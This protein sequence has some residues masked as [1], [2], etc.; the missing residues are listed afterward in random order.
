MAWLYEKSGAW[1]A[2]VRHT[3]DSRLVFGAFGLAVCVVIPYYAVEGIMAWSNPVLDE[4]QIA[5]LRKRQGMSSQI[6][7][8]V[9]KERLATLLSEVQNK[10]VQN[11]EERYRQSLDGR[12]F[13]TMTGSSKPDQK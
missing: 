1:R 10:E 6:L 11:H 7:A 8:S 13:G 9:N 12:T 4:A 2:I 3:R 5:E